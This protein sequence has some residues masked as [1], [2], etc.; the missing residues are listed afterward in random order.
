V[1]GLE[2]NFKA[3]N[4]DYQVNIMDLEILEENYRVVGIR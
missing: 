2:A 1:D 3:V 4:L